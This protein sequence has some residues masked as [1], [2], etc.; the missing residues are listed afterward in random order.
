MDELF[1]FVW[2]HC[3]QPVKVEPPKLKYNKRI[4]ES[5]FRRASAASAFQPVPFRLHEI[6]TQPL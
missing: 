1:A 3:G 2:M 6:R 4:I 5:R